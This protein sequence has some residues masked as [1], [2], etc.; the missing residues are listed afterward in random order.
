MTPHEFRQAREQLGLSV[1]KLADRL[2]VTERSVW[3][4]QSGAQPVPARIEKHLQLLLRAD[5]DTV[6]GLTR[7]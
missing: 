2:S 4:W 7:S 5:P 3:R 1:A 6:S